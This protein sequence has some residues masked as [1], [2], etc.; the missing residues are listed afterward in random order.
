MKPHF[1]KYLKYCQVNAFLLTI[2][3][4]DNLTS[5]LETL[6]LVCKYG[7]FVKLKYNVIAVGKNILLTMG[8]ITCPSPMSFI[9]SF[10]IQNL[11][12]NLTPILPHLSCLVPATGS[13]NELFLYQ[14]ILPTRS[15]QSWFHLII[16]SQ[17]KF[18]FSES[19]LHPY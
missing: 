11:L 13:F 6:E 17:Y 19:P 8:N 5:F 10:L 7:L 4:N 1:G 16:S 9:L 18:T 14:N 2:L 3:Y 12:T 15:V